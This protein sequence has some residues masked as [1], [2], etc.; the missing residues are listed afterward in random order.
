MEGS[1]NDTNDGCEPIGKGMVFCSLASLPLMFGL[2]EWS[3]EAEC[4]CFCL[5]GGRGRRAAVPAGRRAEETGRR[6]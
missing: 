4:W 5:S 2:V 6:V 3:A 1:V